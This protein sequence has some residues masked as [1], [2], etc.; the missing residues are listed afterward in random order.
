MSLLPELINRYPDSY[1][2]VAPAALKLRRSDTCIAVSI[3]KK[4][5]PRS[6]MFKNHATGLKTHMPRKRRR[7]RAD[8]FGCMCWPFAQIHVAPAGAYKIYAL[9]CRIDMS[10]LRRSRF[11]NFSLRHFNPGR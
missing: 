5:S 3:N 9:P 8:K 7:R 11:P 1:I 6:D 4:S 2:P 10:R